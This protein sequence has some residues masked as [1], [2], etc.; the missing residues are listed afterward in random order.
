MKEL[1]L[2]GMLVAFAAAVQ[3]GDCQSCA[4]KQEQT[5]ACCQAKAVAQTKTGKTCPYAAKTAAAAKAKAAPKQALVSPKAMS[6]A[7]R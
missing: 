4:D 3:A 7:S 2:S 1:I 6:L 5:S